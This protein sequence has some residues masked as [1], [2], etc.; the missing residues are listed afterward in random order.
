MDELFGSL[1]KQI[2]VGV[3]GIEVTYSF[4]HSHNTLLVTPQHAHDVLA[5]RPVATFDITNFH[6][7]RQHARETERHA[8]WVLLPVH[9]YFETVAEINVDDLA[10]DTV[11]HQV[12]R[13]AITETQDVTDHG[14]DGERTRVVCAAIKPGF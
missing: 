7:I 1:V 12:T 9:G 8:F 14:H 3:W 5:S 13:V 11:Q 2:S 10:G 6:G 4:K